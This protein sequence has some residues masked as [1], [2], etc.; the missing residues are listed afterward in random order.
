[1]VSFVPA[2]ASLISKGKKLEKDTYVDVTVCP[3]V[4]SKAYSGYGCLSPFGR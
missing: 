2:T 4:Q 3:L 1:M